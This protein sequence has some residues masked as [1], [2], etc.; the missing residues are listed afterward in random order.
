MLQSVPQ[1]MTCKD[2]Q[3]TSDSATMLCLQHHGN[4]ILPPPSQPANSSGFVRPSSASQ[5]P[6][7]QQQQQLTLNNF[8]SQSQEE[9]N[10][11]GPVH[12]SVAALRSSSQ[13]L[14][15]PSSAPAMGGTGCSDLLQASCNADS[16][17]GLK[18]LDQ[19][20]GQGS[21]G[22]TS[23]LMDLEHQKD[24]ARPNQDIKKK[25]TSLEVQLQVGNL[26]HS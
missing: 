19:H 13:T 14:S 9:P 26:H 3:V 17:G 22:R 18:L 12:R 1:L 2:T 24:T 5:W 21:L 20:G 10:H 7:S 23:S 8:W 4:R 15:R 11:S 16:S 25:I 6:A